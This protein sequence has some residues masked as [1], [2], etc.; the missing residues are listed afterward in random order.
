MRKKSVFKKILMIFLV[1]IILIVLVKDVILRIAIQ[2]T[3]SNILGTEVELDSFS[4]GIINQTIKITG[5][6]IQNPEGFPQEEPLLNMPELKVKYDLPELLFKQK[7]HIPLFIL[8]INQMTLVKNKEGELN[9]D[10]L[11]V[12]QEIT[13]EETEEEK[14][15]EEKPAKKMSMQI[16]ELNLSL[17]K[18]VY[19][20][21]SKIE[22]GKP[23]INFH[24]LGIK[25]QKF[26]NIT[27]AEQL[28]GVVLMQGLKGAAIKGAA[29]YGA[30][31]LLGVGFAPLA[32][33]GIFTNKDYASDQIDMSFSKLYDRALGFLR[34]NGAVI[35]EDKTT[36]EIKGK[37]EG[38]DITITI[39]SLGSK[40]T[41][42]KVSA[43]KF[44]IPQPNTAE[45]F[46]YLLKK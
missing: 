11:K 31:A 26:T 7:I 1:L 24:D 44:L 3:A 2:S 12:T 21:Y 43:R 5:F 35:S 30:Q 39:S 41:E 36:G 27:S 45:K 4:W 8:N 14:P 42:I 13:K 10:A 34:K 32:V 16:D 6:R 18:V 25:N 40:K 46:I 38:S 33:A 22:N 17:R 37:Y 19:I 20:D 9:A 28:I 23:E 15:Q 29:L